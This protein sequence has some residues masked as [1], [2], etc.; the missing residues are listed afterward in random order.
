MAA[1]VAIPADV[2]MS[3]VTA[4]LDGHCLA[5]AGL[6]LRVVRSVLGRS[7]HVSLILIHSS[8]VTRMPLTAVCRTTDGMRNLSCV[9]GLSS[10]TVATISRAMVALVTTRVL[11]IIVELSLKVSGV[12]LAVAFVNDR[13]VIVSIELTQ[14]LVK[15]ID[16]RVGS[17]IH[18]NDAVACL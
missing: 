13:D 5:A 17:A 15:L 10:H 14:V 3:P 16:V 2:V 4:H 1:T 6:S 7:S 18:T 9:I 12:Y 11:L 8:V